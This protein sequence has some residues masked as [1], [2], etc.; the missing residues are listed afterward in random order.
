MK[1]SSKKNFLGKNNKDYKKKSDF[2]YYSKNSIRSDQNERFI[3][4]SSKNKNVEN[5]NKKEKNNTFST[6]KRR[7]RFKSK[8]E[9]S[10][11]TLDNHQEFTTKSFINRMFTPYPIIKISLIS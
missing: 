8:S 9:F 11:K 7:D 10:N 6:L 3:N 2:G 4:K 1:N 5:F